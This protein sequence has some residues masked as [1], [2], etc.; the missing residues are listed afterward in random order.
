M[1]EDAIE[2]TC[3]EATTLDEKIDNLFYSI[4]KHEKRA[5]RRNRL[6]QIT[7]VALCVVAGSKIAKSQKT[8]TEEV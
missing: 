6:M 8:E 4:E 3:R 1:T 5:A 7:L 2:T